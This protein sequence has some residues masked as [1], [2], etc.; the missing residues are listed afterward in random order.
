MLG[1]GM[2][3]SCKEILQY[4]IEGHGRHLA[5]PKGERVWLN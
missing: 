2:L 3:S 1:A 4:R 5:G